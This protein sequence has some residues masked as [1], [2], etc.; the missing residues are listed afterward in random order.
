[1]QIISSDTAVVPPEPQN[2]F[3]RLQGVTFELIGSSVQES[4]RARAHPQLLAG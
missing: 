4:G 1:M 3:S 2:D